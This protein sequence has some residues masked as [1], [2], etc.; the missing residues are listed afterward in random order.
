MENT[1]Q[2]TAKA[3]GFQQRTLHASTFGLGF[4]N[5]NNPDC[6]KH[7]EVWNML[8]LTLAGEGKSIQS[9]CKRCK[10]YNIERR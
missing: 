6:F 7:C 8:I 1:I 2:Q 9:M 5:P 10:L 4:G 3:N